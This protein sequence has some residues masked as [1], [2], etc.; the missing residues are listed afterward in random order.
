VITGRTPDYGDQAGGRIK[1]GQFLELVLK[2]DEGLY[3]WTSPG[4]N[5]C[6]VETL[7]GCKWKVVQ[8]LWVQLS[9]LH[10]WSPQCVQS[11]DDRP[12]SPLCIWHG[13]EAA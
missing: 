1:G 6:P 4:G 3:A 11:E 5:V 7:V 9:L 12:V 2:F 8:V 10:D 13:S